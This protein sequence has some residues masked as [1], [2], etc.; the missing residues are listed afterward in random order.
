MGGTTSI[1]S[2]TVC[3]LG[4]G[5]AAHP[6]LGRLFWFDILG[7]RLL[8]QPFASGH[9]T[10]HDLP[11]MASV[12]A[13]VDDHTQLIAA[14][15]GLYLRDVASGRLSLHAALEA[16]NPATR[17]NDG[18]VHPCGALWIGTMG[19]RAETG[20]GA[21]YWFFR[22]ELRR[23]FSDISI[24]N[25][26]AFSPDGSA[27]WFADTA[28]G[29]IWRIATDPVTGLPQGERQVFATI[30]AGEG[31]P[32]GS[33]MDAD[34]LLWNARWGGG[35]LDVYAPDGRRIRSVSI[36]TR[37]PS[38]PAFIGP[39]ADRMAVTTATEGYDNAA[40]AADP[41]AGRTFLLTETVRGRFDPPVR[42]A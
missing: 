15:N 34:G 4:E 12:M 29:I 20:A 11:V 22:G 31:G 38:C 42:L 23:L 21:L 28:L 9:T 35:C 7:R 6:A 2:D 36:P 39:N 41:Q 16:D 13:V 8:E 1:F 27:A 40:L 17:S 37:Q 32:D 10:V 5:P 30:P 26:I 33:V 25:S 14:E 19:K 24:I 3:A 18:R